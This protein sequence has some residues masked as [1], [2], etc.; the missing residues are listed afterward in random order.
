MK[1][2]YLHTLTIRCWHWINAAIIILLTITGI[3]L[4]A[5]DTETLAKSLGIW[6]PNY[7]NAVLIHKYAGFALAASF[8]FWLVY[9]VISGSYLRH[10]LFRPSDIPVMIKQAR[11]YVIGLFKGEKNPF[12]STPEGKFNPL[13]KLTYGIVLPFVVL[14]LIISG[15]LF[16]DIFF[17][18]ETIEHFGG[19]RML[20]ALHVIAAYLCL[21]NFL[22]HLYM[23]TMGHHIFDHIKSMIV[24]YEEVSEEEE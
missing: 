16:S 1:K 19:I 17:F 12:V 5:P 3:Q 14:V 22:V 21:L 7:T 20:D 23:T 9:V 10:Y 13:Q 4:R 15:V 18:R 24:G 2:V 8:L 11:Y 6:F